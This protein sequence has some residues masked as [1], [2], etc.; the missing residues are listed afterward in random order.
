[1][2]T[3][4]RPPELTMPVSS[5]AALRDALV[6]A[7]GAEAAAQA[8]RQAGYAAGDALFAF[9][10]GSGERQAGDIPATQFWS[11][12]GRLF[13]SR[14]WGQLTFSPAHEGVGALDAGDWFEARLDESGSADQ[15]SCHFT[16]GVLANVLGQVAGGEVAVLEVDCR[17]RGD[18]RC[19]FLF[20]GADA[21]YHVYDQMSAGT[22]PD[23]ALAQLR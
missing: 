12:L 13:A 4:S 1:M 11:D 5:L 10:Q 9:L 23:S 21:V 2:T 15:P 8:L 16:I 3:S 17:S 20:G 19:R 7:V 14:G 6:E 18:A 22:P